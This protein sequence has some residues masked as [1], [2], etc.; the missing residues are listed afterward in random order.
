MQGLR[1]MINFFLAGQIAQTHKEGVDLMIHKIGFELVAQFIVHPFINP[2][3]FMAQES[4]YVRRSVFLQKNIERRVLQTLDRI[5]AGN[6]KLPVTEKSPFFPQQACHEKFS[7]VFTFIQCFQQSRM[8]HSVFQF[9]QLIAE[10]Y[11]AI[12]FPVF[13]QTYCRQ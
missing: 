9:Q 4:P 2:E 1:D 12:S 13:F 11:E 5:V 7:R 8:T 10:E 3:V 6:E